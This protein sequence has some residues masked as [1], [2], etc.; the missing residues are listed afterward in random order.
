MIRIELLQNEL[1]ALE[2]VIKPM[3]MQT[4]TDIILKYTNSANSD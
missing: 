3:P 4:I 2:F 1:G